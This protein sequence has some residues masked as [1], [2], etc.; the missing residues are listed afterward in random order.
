MT[1]LATVTVWLPERVVRLTPDKF[2][3][4]LADGF[5]TPKP[6]PVANE[7]RSTEPT[8]TL[9]SLVTTTRQQTRQTGRPPS[10]RQRLPRPRSPARHSAGLNPQQPSQVR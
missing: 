7:R 9:I 8:R 3:A 2:P 10:E 1:V 5:K 6:A 4:V